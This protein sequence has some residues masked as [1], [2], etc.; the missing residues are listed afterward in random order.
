MRRPESQKCEAPG[1]PVLS[2]PRTD[3][4]PERYPSGVGRVTMLRPRFSAGPSPAEESLRTPAGPV[5]D[6]EESPPVTGVSDQAQPCREHI[7]EPLGKA[8]S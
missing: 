4:T 6:A 1:Q 5:S 7:A 8:V 3:G 2:A